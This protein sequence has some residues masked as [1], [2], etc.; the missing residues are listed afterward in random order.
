M[1]ST[2][3]PSDLPSLALVSP[4]LEP[5]TR[6]TVTMT[7]PISPETL[8][9]YL[10]QFTGSENYYRHSLNRKF[11]HTDGVNYLAEKAGAFWLVD[12]IASHQLSRKVRAE[13]F[14][15]WTLTLTGKKN[16]MAVAECRADTDAPVLAR[17]KIEFTDFPLKSIKLYCVDG[18]DGQVILMLPSE[19]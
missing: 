2:K 9:S 1:A 14:Q 5:V 18:G 10:A 8:E 3:L 7:D 15:V 11:M 17:Q 19:Y 6:K 13:P 16:P 12:L 4:K